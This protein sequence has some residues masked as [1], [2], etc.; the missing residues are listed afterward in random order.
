MQTC[1]QCKLR[2][3]ISFKDNLGQG[4]SSELKFKHLVPII[5]GHLAQGTN[6]DSIKQNYGIF[7]Q[8]LFWTTVRKN[9]LVIEKNFWNSRLKAENL[10]NVCDHKN[11]LFEQWKVSTIFENRMLF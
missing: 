7:F 4:L 5:I 10:K 2:P 3:D 1:T 8:K 11:D 9:I 6:N